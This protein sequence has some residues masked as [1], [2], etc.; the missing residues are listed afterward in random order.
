MPSP[1][2]NKFFNARI[3]LPKLLS[4]LNGAGF[5]FLAFMGITGCTILP[6]NTLSLSQRSTVIQDDLTE[7]QVL[8]KAFLKESRDPAVN[9]IR[10]LHLK[11]TPYEMGFQHGRLLR[12]QVRDA[13]YHVLKKV[14]FLVPKDT[15]DEVYDL[16]SPYIPTEEKE[17]MRGLAHG[18][19]IPL[20]LIHWIHA[21]PELSEYK[22]RKQFRH[23]LSSTSCSNL[24]AFGDAT[25]NQGFFQLRV[26][27][28]NRELGTHKWPVILVHRPDVGN[29]SVTFSFAGFIGAVSGM[30]D[31][32]MAFGEKGEGSKV[33]ETL[34]GTPFVFLFRKL[35]REA[36]TL[37]QAVRMIREAKRTCAYS[38]LIS[39][40][41]AEKTKAFLI[42]SDK[43]NV[44][45]FGPDRPFT[46]PRN[47]K[48]YPGIK[49]VVYNGAD[50]EDLFR[51]IRSDYGKINP[52]TLK[53]IS[54]KVARQSN[55]QNVIF[56]PLTLESWVSHAATSNR[57]EKGRASNQAWFYF[58]FKHALHALSR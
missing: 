44:I 16:M 43:E 14:T 47:Q 11:G 7:Q 48:Q 38:F 31:Q 2:V 19:G 5:I 25:A 18:A 33:E 37:D 1:L 55:I 57:D 58:N 49:D 54:I 17:E 42:F 50:K 8:S 26:L 13:V 39:D 53:K 36:D 41:K 46:D 56:N 12:K 24:A 51:A 3:V 21:L 35:M 52:A 34:E 23:K 20:R 15:L 6:E 29:A 30:N 9:Y 32:Y 10:V 45:L 28:W 40:A 22:G 4:I 27:D